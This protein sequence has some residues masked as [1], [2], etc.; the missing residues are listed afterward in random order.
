MRRIIAA[1]L[2]VLLSVFSIAVRSD[3]P[4]SSAVTFNREVI[5]ILHRKCL[6]CHTPGGIAM[7]LATYRD[8]RPWSRAIREELV[9]RRMPPWSAAPGYAPLA[10]DPALTA[11]EMAILLTWL[12]GGVP[13][14]D[15]R[16]LPAPVPS[17]GHHAAAPDH[18][19]RL[20]ELRIP[21][22]QD[23][24]VRRVT[25]DAGMDTAR[26]IARIEIHPGERRALRAAF[27]SV[28]TPRGTQ[29]I[30][31]WTPWRPFIAAPDGT[32]FTVPAG[33][34]IE[35]ELHYRGGEADVHDR[36]SISMSD[37]LGGADD[38][39]Q[40]VIATSAAKGRRAG[41]VR[42]RNPQRIWAIVPQS[43]DTTASDPG[44]SIEV[45]AREP[46]GTVQVLLWIPRY[47]SAWPT[48][49]VLGHPIELPAGSELTA[50]AVGVPLNRV[51]LVTTTRATRPRS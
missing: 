18:L 15:E 7:S 5:R 29:W 36:S 8:V 34:K 6:Q 21:A 25:V 46:D 33:A 28:V 42:L 44:G 24:V 23:H 35:A 49:Y 48:P 47:H 4:V 16:D 32:A 19:V 14:G 40:I 31:A 50:V 20:P 11:R 26:R 37:A 2:L 12:D 51:T 9:E 17:A 3:D 13:R 41:A 39:R 38:V 43:L 10:D 1:V 30:G 22:N 27:V 45:T